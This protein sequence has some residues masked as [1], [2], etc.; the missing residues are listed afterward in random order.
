MGMIYHIP[1]PPAPRDEWASAYLVQST[2]IADRFAKAVEDAIAARGGFLF[3]DDGSPER[4]T[5]R[6]VVVDTRA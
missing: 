1:E 2:K 3:A 6:G 4:A 5:V